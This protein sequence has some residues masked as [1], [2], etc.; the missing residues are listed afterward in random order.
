MKITQDELGNLLVKLAFGVFIYFCARYVYEWTYS[1]YDSS[2]VF[3]IG[4]GGLLLLAYI[5]KVKLPYSL[6]K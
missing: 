2:T 5:F 6:R 4:I 3:W 1:K